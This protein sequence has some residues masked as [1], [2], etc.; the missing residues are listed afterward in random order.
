MCDCKISLSVHRN[1][2]GRE[3]S[4]PAVSL[5]RE[6]QHRD[7]FCMSVN[8][9]PEVNELTNHR[10]HDHILCKRRASMPDHLGVE[11]AS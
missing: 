5:N 7:F 6:V 11:L 9:N 4:P 2:T 1:L 8:S 3:I 10:E